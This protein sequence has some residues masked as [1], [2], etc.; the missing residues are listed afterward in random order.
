MHARTLNIPW[1]TNSQ[2][3]VAA[4]STSHAYYVTLADEAGGMGGGA[5]AAGLFVQRVKEI[6]Q[7]ASRPDEALSSLSLLDL[8][9]EAQPQ[10]GEA[11]GIVTTDAGMSSARTQRKPERRL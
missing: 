4:F 1:S 9:M 3:R 5:E 7:A 10:R 8:Q 6:A 2:D 11:T